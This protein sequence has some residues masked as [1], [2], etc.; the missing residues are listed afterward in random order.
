VG[1]DGGEL[2]VALDNLNE[3]YFQ[4]IAQVAK[5]LSETLSLLFEAFAREL[6]ALAQKI[7]LAP[8]GRAQRRRGACA[9]EAAAIFGPF[10][11]FKDSRALRHACFVLILKGETGWRSRSL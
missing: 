6:N 2:D 9:I 10:C 3:R 8:E 7:A 5:I 11:I 4:P 1:L